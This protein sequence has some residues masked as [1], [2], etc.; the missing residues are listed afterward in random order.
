M[1]PVLIRRNIWRN[2]RRTLITMASVTFAVVLAITMRSLQNGIF[3]KLVDDL[4]GYYTGYLQVHL[5]GYQ[6][7]QSLDNTM[8]F[9]KELLL[10]VTQSENVRFA[11][12]RIESF[13]LSASGTITRGCLLVGTM[14]EGERRMSGLD[15]RLVAG[16]YFS[17]EAREVLIAEKLAAKLKLRHGDTL[18]LLG[19]GYQG[20]TAAGKYPVRGIVHF[21]TPA[22]NESLVFMPL[23]AC[24]E[25]L[26]TGDRITALAVNLENP[27]R[28]LATQQALAAKAGSIHEVVSWKEMLP[29][30]DNHIRS[31]SANFYLFF[32]VLYIL[33]A[34][35][36]FGTVLMMLNERR[37]E[38]GILLAIGMSRARIAFMLAGETV[39]IALTGALAGVAISLPLVLYLVAYPIHFKGSVAEAYS[40][41]GF[42]P[43][44]PASL[45]WNVFLVQ[46]LIVLAI[47]LLVSVYPCIAVWQLQAVK[48]IRR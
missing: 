7:E 31:D 6:D 9:E 25:L 10:S 12:P 16:S 3:E 47:A 41:F 36:M 22:L 32:G 38:L 42:D 1:I 43:V 30:I 46:T 14:P 23:S 5:R 33:I 2:R 8:S 28:L 39:L 18:V 37:Y 11:V 4:V 19:Q 20:M 29:D 13:M 48:S 26:G 44:W 27:S 34:F 17:K 45:D 35:G 15:R 24:Q 21:G 40:R